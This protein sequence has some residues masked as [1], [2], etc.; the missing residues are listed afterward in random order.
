[1]LAALGHQQW[2][3]RWKGANICGW[4]CEFR[5]GASW[6]PHWDSLTT[7]PFF[8]PLLTTLMLRNANV[9]GWQPPRHRGLINPS[10]PSLPCGQAPSMK[11]CLV[12]WTQERGH[13]QQHQ[14]QTLLVLP[15]PL[16]H[17]AGTQLLDSV[18]M[19][20][21][22]ERASVG[23]CWVGSEWCWLKGAFGMISCCRRM[24]KE[25]HGC[26]LGIEL[27]DHGHHDACGSGLANR[28]SCVFRSRPWWGA[29]EQL[30]CWLAPACQ[31]WL[32]ASGNVKKGQFYYCY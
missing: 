10:E 25:E 30:G 1:M 2:Q 7:H 12:G 5:L 22:Q 6:D 4:C 18:C 27:P 20:I 26:I 21:D 16:C 24:D 9:T 8:R 19:W 15:S 14:W 28:A 23:S 17:C 29:L 13:D 11:V 3:L 31:K 32:A